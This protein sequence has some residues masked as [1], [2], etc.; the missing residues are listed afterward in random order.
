MNRTDMLQ[1]LVAEPAGWDVLVIGGGATGLGAAV[2]AAARGYRTALVEQADFAQGT[3]S[4]STKLIHG[5]VRY[6]QQ[7]R[8]DLVRESLRERRRLLHNAPHLVRPLPFVVPNYEWWER[9]FYGTGLRLYDFLGGDT[10]VEPTRHLSREATLERLPT[11]KPDGLRGGILYHDAQFD[12]ARLAIALAQ[13]AADLGSVVIN[14]V[15]VVSLLKQND[16]IIG[17]RV[18]DLES[19]NDFE[20]RARVVINA[21]GVFADEV[22]Q[23]DNAAKP[24]LLT[25]SQGAHLVL[26]KSFLPGHCALMAP[27]TADGRIFFAIPWHGRVLIGTTETAVPSVETE[28]RPLPG[29]VEFLLNHAAQHLIR[30]PVTS[31]I[32]GAF[33]GLRPLLKG[34]DGKLTSALSRSHLVEVAPSGLVTIT[35][36][37]WTTYRQMAED[38]VNRATAV[39]GLPRR[40]S[41]TRDLRLHDASD[42]VTQDRPDD[43]PLHPRLP[44]RTGEVR[45]AVRQAMARSIADVLARRTRALLLDARASMEIAPDVAGIM[46]AELG[47]DDAWAAQQVKSFCELAHGSLF[48]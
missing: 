32:L 25:T 11:L 39:G 48:P 10:G 28:P 2:D 24:A 43:R 27:R 44:Y 13:T 31:D 20:V 26:D 42:Q 35:G 16:R 7:G 5:G 30:A 40:E 18:R 47:R 8:I 33:A 4:R 1:R 41:R 29:E 46:A 23:L 37:K 45:W 17:A 19:G 21:T 38:A 3:S 34:A 22:R 12:D 36:G 9:G 15:K 6:L 14:Y